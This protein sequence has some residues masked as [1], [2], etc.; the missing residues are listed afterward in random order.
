[1][2]P[3]FLKWILLSFNLDK[4]I[5]A[6]RGINATQNKITNSADPDKTARLKQDG[7]S[8]CLLFSLFFFFFFF[9]FFCFFFF[10]QGSKC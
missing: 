4:F 7:S 5:V 8:H 9:V 3:A 10:V 1:M 2:D 6:D